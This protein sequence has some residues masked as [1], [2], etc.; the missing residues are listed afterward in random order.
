MRAR[1][2]AAKI[3]SRAAVQISATLD[4]L[5]LV[6]ASAQLRVRR[7]AIIKV[8]ATAAVASAVPTTLQVISMEMG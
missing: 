2:K 7:G 4:A 1:P 3:R 8:Q 6:R 5:I